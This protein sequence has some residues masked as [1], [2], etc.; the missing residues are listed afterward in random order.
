M[1][2]NETL[3]CIVCN[4]CV[5]KWDHHC[6]WLEKC[7]ND[8]NVVFFNIINFCV[9]FEI[10]INLILS[11]E[12]L[13]IFAFG[14]LNNFVYQEVFLISNQKKIM[15]INILLS[16]LFGF[17]LFLLIL[18]FG[19]LVFMMY[20]NHVLRTRDMCQKLKKE[21]LLVNKV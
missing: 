10:L 8:Y 7:V 12:G 11:F 1:K 21:Q 20:M 13:I 9:V 19:S 3:H 17:F 4:C 6:H 18:I 14:R 5:E 2:D 15:I 16:S